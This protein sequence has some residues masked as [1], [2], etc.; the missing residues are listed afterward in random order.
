MSIKFGLGSE[1]GTASARL[2]RLG[3]DVLIFADLIKQLC[4]TEFVNSFN[5]EFILNHILIHLWCSVLQIENLSS[6]VTR[7]SRIKKSIRNFA[8]C[9][10]SPFFILSSISLKRLCFRY[11][12]EDFQPDHSGN[13][14]H[15]EPKTCMEFDLV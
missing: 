12:V 4:I 15:I 1:L 3:R 7:Q 6:D 14:L 9:R 5:R 13:L 11:K 10:E 8:D 2:L